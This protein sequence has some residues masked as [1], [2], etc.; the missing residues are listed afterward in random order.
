L[1]APLGGEPTPSL[2]GVSR[3][4]PPRTIVRM[5]QRGVAAS[6]GSDGIDLDGLHHL[7]A[8]F[9]IVFSLI[10]ISGIATTLRKRAVTV[11]VSTLAVVS[12]VIRWMRHVHPSVDRSRVSVP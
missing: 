10:V 3:A 8:I 2:L 1:G 11:F 9:S 6:A 5:T 7:D 12:L 4:D